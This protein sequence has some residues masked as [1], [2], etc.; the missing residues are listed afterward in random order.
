MSAPNVRVEVREYPDDDKGYQTLIL[1]NHWNHN[2]RVH[3][4]IEGKEYLFIISD[5][6]KALDAIEASR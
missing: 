5:L 6:R 1:R 2:G 4:E 3:M